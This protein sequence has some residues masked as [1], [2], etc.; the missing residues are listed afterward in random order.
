M[1]CSLC[2]AAISRKYRFRIPLI[3][4]RYDLMLSLFLEPALDLK[5]LRQF[6]AVYEEKSMTRAAGRCHISQPALSNAIRHLEDDIGR[7]LFNRTS[8][9]TQPTRE[10]EQLYPVALRSL[11]DFDQISNLFSAP[12]S[13]SP[14]TLGVMPELP[15]R[16]VAKFYRIVRA[17][18]PVNPLNLVHHTQSCDARIILDVMKD[19]DE[20]FT[21]LWQEQYCFVTHR[22]HPLAQKDRVETKDLDGQTFI[23]CPPCESHQRTLGLLGQMG[24]SPA[25]TLSAMS[26]DMVRQLLIANAGVSFLPEY[27]STEWEELVVRP[28]DGPT[29][30]RTAG[31]AWTS[32]RMPSPEL[33]TVL[34]TFRL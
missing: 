3:T 26:K 5:L 32:G 24:L 29:L 7:I 4:S 6:V 28:F 31:L 18:L 16:E 20:L 21:P 10:A 15:Q 27:M 9:G 2:N 14:L 17:L 13:A 23:V 33:E 22:D 30:G 19:E 34:N 1:C 12:Q 8:Q 11:K 25:L